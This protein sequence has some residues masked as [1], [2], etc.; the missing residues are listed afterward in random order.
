MKPIFTAAALLLLTACA[1]LG[2][3]E[4]TGESATYGSDNILR[5]DVLNTVNQYERAAFDCRHV[6]AIHS[7][8]NQI[9]KPEG[10]LSVKETWTVTACG[11]QHDYHISLRQD[12]RGETDFSVGLAK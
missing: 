1:S 10:R 12:E 4:F 9:T 5:N 2:G 7:R 3:T 6:S 11:K 8:I